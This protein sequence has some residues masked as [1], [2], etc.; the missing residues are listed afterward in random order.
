MS[1]INI[2]GA[3]ANYGMFNTAFATYESATQ[4]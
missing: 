4:S 1:A 3:T 2:Y